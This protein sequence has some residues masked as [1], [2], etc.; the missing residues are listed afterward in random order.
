MFENFELSELSEMSEG[1]SCLIGLHDSHYLTLTGLF[2]KGHMRSSYLWVIA[3]D[4]ARVRDIRT[5][6]LLG[7]ISIT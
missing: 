4:D 7:H 1:Q 6:I 2:T 3:S 5:G